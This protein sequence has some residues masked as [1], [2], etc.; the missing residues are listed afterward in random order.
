MRRIYCGIACTA[1]D[2][3]I[4]LVNSDGEVLYAQATERQTQTKRAWH[5]HACSGVRTGRVSWHPLIDKDTELTIGF[6]WRPDSNQVAEAS[7][8]FATTEGELT[9]WWTRTRPLHLLDPVQFYSELSVLETIQTRVLSY[10][11]MA[12]SPS[13]SPLRAPKYCVHHTTHAAN[14][15]YS[16][17]FTEATCAIIDGLGERTSTAFFHWADGRLTP[18]DSR[19]DSPSDL[20]REGSLGLFYEALCSACGFDPEAGEEWKVMGLSAYGRFDQTLY[21]TLRAMV[22]VEDLRLATNYRDAW[23]GWRSIRRRLGDHS[24]PLVYADLAHTGQRVFEEVSEEL[25]HNLRRRGLSDNLVLGGGCALNSLW[26]GK[27]VSRTGFKSLFVP[28]APADDGNAVGAAWLAFQDDHPDWRPTT[29]TQLPYLG[30][31][32]DELPLRNAMTLGGLKPCDLKGR[33]ISRYTAELV[34]AGNI[35]GWIQGKA[36][37]GPRALGN[38]SIIADA[39]VPDIKN[40]INTK[41]KFREDYRPFAPSILHER[42]NEYFEDYQESPYMDRTLRLRPAVRSKIPGVV[43]EDATGRLQSV[44]REWNDRYYDLIKEFD[45]L[46]DVP[47]VLNTSFNVMGKPIVHS[48]E[49]ALSVYMTTGMDALVIG[50]VIF[51]KGVS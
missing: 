4:A 48:V 9:E 21:E 29:T 41:V 7:K 40:I 10:L 6:S 37:F 39:R 11:L 16:S 34:A 19:D 14:A 18:L 22:R 3:A 30:D 42:G 25:L 49:D 43:H 24:N 50:D 1:H 26:N 35:V 23:K 31:E 12:R 36:E 44:K 51:K 17:P 38:R 2:P 27:I 13:G 5:M 28:C 45:R 46:T 15:C 20:H 32:M 8:L 47:L 33:T